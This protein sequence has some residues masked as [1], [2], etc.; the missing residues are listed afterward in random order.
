[1]L[2]LFNKDWLKV[3]YILGILNYINPSYLRNRSDV[4]YI[5]YECANYSYLVYWTPVDISFISKDFY[6]HGSPPMKFWV[7]SFN[8]FT[9]WTNSHNVCYSLRLWIIYLRKVTKSDLK[10]KTSAIKMQKHIGNWEPENVLRNI[11]CISSH[12]ALSQHHRLKLILILVGQSCVGGVCLQTNKISSVRYS[13]NLVS[14]F[15]SCY[16][17]IFDAF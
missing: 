9:A 16:F 1:M 14:S 4:L 3:L 10:T 5:K 8:V 12:S 2:Q 6:M 7:D 11:S 13:V 15:V 17:G